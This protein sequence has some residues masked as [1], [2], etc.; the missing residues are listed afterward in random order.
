MDRQRVIIV[1]KYEKHFEES[2]LLYKKKKYPDFLRMFSHCHRKNCVSDSSFDFLLMVSNLTNI[3][4]ENKVEIE[5]KI[6]P[7]F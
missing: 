5:P 3:V 1:L 2:L 6:I 7:N 4:K